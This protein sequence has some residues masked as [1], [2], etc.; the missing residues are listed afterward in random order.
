MEERQGTSNFLS[1]PSARC[2]LVYG[3]TFAPS[4]VEVLDVSV[5]FR[6][7][8]LTRLRKVLKREASDLLVTDQP[9]Q[10]PKSPV[11]RNSHQRRKSLRMIMK[12]RRTKDKL[13]KSCVAQ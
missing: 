9:P 1:T 2:S 10:E 4:A 8:P 7:S 6:K 5:N 3:T 12:K 13:Q 11:R